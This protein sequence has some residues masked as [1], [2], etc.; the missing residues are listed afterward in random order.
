MVD[1]SSGVITGSIIYNNHTIVRIVLIQNR[2]QVS[3]VSEV[4]SVV[5]RRNDDAEGQFS[6]VLTHVVQWLQTIQLFF[7]LFFDFRLLE[8]VDEGCFQVVALQNPRVSA[9][10]RFEIVPFN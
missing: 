7:K 1:E 8:S 10:L 6:R 5:V 4:F 9:L 3:L 2:L